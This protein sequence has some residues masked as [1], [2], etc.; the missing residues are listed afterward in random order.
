MSRCVF[1]L[2]A[3]SDLQQIHDYIAQDSP[4]SAI[5]IVDRLEGMCLLLADQPRMGRRQAGARC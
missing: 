3:R 4:R 1:S 5:R 2:E